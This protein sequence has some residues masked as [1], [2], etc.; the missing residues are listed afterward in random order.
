MEG[1]DKVAQKAKGAEDFQQLF[2]LNWDLA[3]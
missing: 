3:N 2:D 1:V